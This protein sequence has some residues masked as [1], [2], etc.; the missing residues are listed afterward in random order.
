VPLTKCPDC[1]REVSQ[2][3]WSCPGCGKPF[4]SPWGLK[5]KTLK[6]GFV[7]WF[8]LILAFLS[9]WQLLNQPKG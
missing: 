6:W 9:V 1:G 4:R 8:V 5:P 7:V 2:E 3:A